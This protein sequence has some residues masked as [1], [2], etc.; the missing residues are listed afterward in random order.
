MTSGIAALNLA[1]PEARK[2]LS[3]LTDVDVSPSAF[4]YMACR[5][6]TVAGVPAT[7]LRVGFVGET[8]WEIHFPAEYGEYMWDTLLEAGAAAG[9]RPF[10]VE[11]QRLLRLEK[12][13]VIVGQDTDALSNPYDCDMSW[14]VKLDKPDFIGR[15]ALESIKSQPSQNRLVGFYASDG[16]Q[17]DDGNA[18]VINGKLVGRVTSARFSPQLKKYIGL[19]WVPAGSAKPGTTVGIRAADKIYSAVIV[20]EPFYDPEGKRLK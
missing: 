5:Q 2:V 4:P 20:E 8:G 17:P 13:H 9:I 6:G 18:I 16:G 1:G 10:G 12:K 3:Q 15:H 14:V 11:T 19:A 7:L